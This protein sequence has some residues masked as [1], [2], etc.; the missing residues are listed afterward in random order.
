MPPIMREISIFTHNYGD[1]FIKL[2]CNSVKDLKFFIT[3]YENIRQSL[4]GIGSIWKFYIDQELTVLETCTSRHHGRQIK[5][6]L[7]PLLYHITMLSRGLRGYTERREPHKWSISRVPVVVSAYILFSGK[8]GIV[9][10]YR[11]R[12]RSESRF[13]TLRDSSTVNDRQWFFALVKSL[14][15]VFGTDVSWSSNK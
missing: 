12:R 15:K 13:W 1:C 2:D 5:T 7:T 9:F 6:L 4:D 11:H 8:W 3:G 10:R 14:Q